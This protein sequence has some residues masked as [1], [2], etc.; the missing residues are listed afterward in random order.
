MRGLLIDFNN[1]GVGSRR[2]VD[3]ISSRHTVDFKVTSKVNLRK[4]D[5]AKA[6][7]IREIVTS[8]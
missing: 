8:I 7:M 1:I 6:V 5:P 4:L 2:V 3:R